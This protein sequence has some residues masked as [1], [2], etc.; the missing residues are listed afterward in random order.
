MG[1]AVVES[2][3]ERSGVLNGLV[4]LFLGWSSTATVLSGMDGIDVETVALGGNRQL[5][6]TVDAV[7]RLEV[8]LAVE[9]ESS[10]KDEAF[11]LL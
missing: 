6:P 5:F 11:S 3:M 8:Q 1:S 7:P 2:C 9:P 4:K 10:A